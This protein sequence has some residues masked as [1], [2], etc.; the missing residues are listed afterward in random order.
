MKAVV[1]NILYL[2]R[3]RDG[4]TTGNS[5]LPY[6][7][8]SRWWKEN[9]Y[10]CLVDIYRKGFPSHSSS[11]SPMFLPPGKAWS[12]KPCVFFITSSFVLCFIEMGKLASWQAWLESAKKSK[13]KLKSEVY[14]LV[15]L[16]YNYQNSPGNKP[17]HC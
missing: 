4:S 12:W 2:I 8:Q 10:N 16:D 5:M 17:A 11:H 1:L 9:I 3:S 15:F 6:F 13:P 7:S 14:G